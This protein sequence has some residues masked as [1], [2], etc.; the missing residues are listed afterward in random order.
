MHTEPGITDR[1]FELFRVLVRRHTG[2][3]L[4]PQKRLLL[5]A[6]LGKRLRALGLASFGE[7]YEALTAADGDGVELTRFINAVT[8]NK[9]DFFRE[10]HHFRHLEEVWLPDVR[11]H[12]AR[13]ADRA[14]RLWSAGCSTGEEPYT[15][16]MVLRDGL[17]SLAGWNV[18]I[19]ASDIDTDVLER[20][21]AGIYT[22]E[23]A[24]GV[25][26]ALLPRHF[27]RG[28]GQQEGLVRVRPEVHALVTFR[29]INLLEE[30]WPIRRPLDVVFC[31]NVLIYFDRPTQQR[32]LARIASLLKPEGLLFLGHSESAYGLLED[33]QHLGNTIYRLRPPAE[34]AP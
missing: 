4:G 25:P 13:D 27:L 29:R 26:A 21:A 10:P 8:T 34:A 5:Q 14:L 11:R 31:R 18:R 32:I 6:R 17:G 23:Q 7:Y 30:P 12:A 28:R 22:L 19:L 2:I 9:T 20:A 33:V 1:E 16:A 3:A 24:A 15:I